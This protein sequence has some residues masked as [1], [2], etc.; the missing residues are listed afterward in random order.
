[1]NVRNEVAV[2]LDYCKY[3]KELA[4]K[5]LKAYRIDLQQFFSFCNCD[6]P[7]KEIIEQFIIDLHKRYKQKTVKRKIASIKAFYNFLEQEEIIEYSPFRK[8][9]VQF[10]ETAVLPRIISRKDIE[11]LLNYMYACQTKGNLSD[12]RRC[13]CC[14]NVFFNRCKGL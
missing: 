14:R 2:Y 6:I 1:M 3:R 5:T 10:K 9:K 7:E 12:R 8:I 13:S 11:R 4:E